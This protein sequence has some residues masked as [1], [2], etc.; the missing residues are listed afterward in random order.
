MKKSDDCDVLI[1]GS[2][3]LSAPEEVFANIANSLGNRV[4]RMPD[5]ETGACTHERST[6]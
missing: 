2:V 4:R 3:P 5:G 1:L 6:W